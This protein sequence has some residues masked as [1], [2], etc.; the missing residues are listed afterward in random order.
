MNAVMRFFSHRLGGTQELLLRM[1]G[2]E[3]GVYRHLLRG[4]LYVPNH[5]GWIWC[6][7]QRVLRRKK[8]EQ[9]WVTVRTGRYVLLNLRTGAARYAKMAI[10]VAGREL[11]IIIPL[12]PRALS[13]EE[14]AEFDLKEH[15][16]VIIKPRRRLYHVRFHTALRWPRKS[17]EYAHLGS[18]LMQRTLARA[19]WQ[20][21]APPDALKPFIDGLAASP[22]EARFTPS[23]WGRPIKIGDAIIDRRGVHTIVR[24]NNGEGVVWTTDQLLKFA[25]CLQAISGIKFWYPGGWPW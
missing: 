3:P 24:D 11:P 8:D 22:P 20:T 12:L 4:A 9:A 13:P 17:R 21:F 10:P 18:W 1:F 7:E 15:E 2:H 25:M 14:A 6:G 23:T 16:A 5:Q 19:I